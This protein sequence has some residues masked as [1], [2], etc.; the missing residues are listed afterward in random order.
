MTPTSSKHAWKCGTGFSNGKQ[1]WSG[2]FH[3]SRRLWRKNARNTRR[4]R[5]VDRTT[6]MKMRSNGSV[7]LAWPSLVQSKGSAPLTRV[8][9]FWSIEKVQHYRWAFMSLGYCKVLG[10]AASRNPSWEEAVV[11]LNQLL[12]RRIAKGLRASINPVIRNDLEHL[13][14]W[15]DTSDFTKTGKNGFTVQCKPISSLPEGY[16]FD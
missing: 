10:T 16:T 14:D 5:V 12:F 6:E 15:R 2:Y 1:S 4:R 8:S 13:C 11:K 3:V 7:L 9:G